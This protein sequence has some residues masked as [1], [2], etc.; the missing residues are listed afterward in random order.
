M[1]TTTQMIDEAKAQF[2]KMRDSRAQSYQHRLSGPSFRLDSESMSGIFRDADFREYEFD[3]CLFQQ[4]EFQGSDLRGASF[5]YSFLRFTYFV[6]CNLR[7]VHFNACDLYATQFVNCDLSRTRFDHCN[8]HYSVLQDCHFEY[9]D[10]TGSNLSRSK[11]QSEIP[12][13][14]DLYNVSGNG[15]EIKTWQSDTYAVAYTHD[16]VQIGCQNRSLEQWLLMDRATKARLGGAN[17]LEWSKK[18]KSTLL[19]MIQTNPAQPPRVVRGY[20]ADLIPSI[21]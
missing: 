9:T 7:G 10:F 1:N 6:N 19:K 4:S 5:F 15:T 14:V 18:N 3:R 12:G 13:T 20:Q 17:G 11:F 16:R 8:L 2:Q 21:D